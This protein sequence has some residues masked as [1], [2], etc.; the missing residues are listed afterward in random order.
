MLKSDYKG[1]GSSPRV[2]CV[3]VY[4][5]SILAEAWNT[6]KTS[7]LQDKY[8]SYRYYNPALPAKNHAEIAGL[9][10][11][12]W[13]CGD[14]LNWD[15]ME[16]YLYRETRKGTMALSRPC[17]SCLYALRDAGVKNIYYTTEN[18]YAKEELL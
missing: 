18:G 14:S 7:P 8:N 2:G 17:R 3:F 11:V 12:R 6:N 15:K 1:S 4:K 13:R 5:G 9:M 16:V 10:K